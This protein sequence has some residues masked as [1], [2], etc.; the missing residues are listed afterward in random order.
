MN[1]TIRVLVVDDNPIV[2]ISGGAETI[3]IRSSDM[4]GPIPFR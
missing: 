4:L 1:A 3:L 2:R